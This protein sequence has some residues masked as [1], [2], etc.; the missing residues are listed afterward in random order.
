MRNFRND[1]AHRRIIRARYRL[2]HFS[3]AQTFNNRFLFFGIT[4]HTFIVLNLDSSAVIRVF[5][6]FCHCFLSSAFSIQPSA[7][8]VLLTTD[9]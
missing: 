5:I 6:F 8:S 1:A 7:F 2:I 4:N 9:T 3:D